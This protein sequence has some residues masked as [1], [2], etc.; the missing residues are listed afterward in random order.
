[1][2]YQTKFLLQQIAD[3]INH[4]NDAMVMLTIVNVVLSIAL[5]IATIRLGRQQSQI[6]KNNIKSQLFD[7]RYKVYEAIVDAKAFLNREDHLINGF[8]IKN[9][10]DNLGQ[11]FL[12]KIERLNDAQLSAEALFGYGIHEKAK[13]ITVL[14]A[15]ARTKFFELNLVGY[16]YSN[17]LSSDQLKR[18]RQ[19]VLNNALDFAT[20][21]CE[22]E[23]IIP[24]IF[25][26]IPEWEDAVKNFNDYIRDSGIMTYFDDYL[27]ISDIDK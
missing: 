19:M 18:I 21:R 17:Q 24:G 13:N 26:K 1:M 4:S 22:I 12:D 15:K 7:R 20:M 11:M 2:D 23:K 10:F 25:G 14:F 8:Y 9:Y 16:N 6:Q 5:V 27:K 3:A